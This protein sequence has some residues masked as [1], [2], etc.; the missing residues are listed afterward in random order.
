M[1]FFRKIDDIRYEIQFDRPY[2]LK[3]VL[4]FISKNIIDNY[5]VIIHN[6][7]D[8]NDH[9]KYV[10]KCIYNYDLYQVDIYIR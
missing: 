7:K 1:M 5:S 10:C 8:I 3:E 6:D 2:N 9:Y 4:N